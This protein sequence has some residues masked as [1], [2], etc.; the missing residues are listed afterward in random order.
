MSH[1]SLA[2]PSF[3]EMLSL[4]LLSKAL[5]IKIYNT[6][7][8]PFVLYRVERLCINLRKGR[9]LQVSENKIPRKIFISQKDEV[10]GDTRIV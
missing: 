9:N 8:L 5:Q 1:N 10:N 2:C 3:Q 4:R 6:M 7:I